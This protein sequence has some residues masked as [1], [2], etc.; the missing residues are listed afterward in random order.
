MRNLRNHSR[1]KFFNVDAG[2][3]DPGRISLCIVCFILGEFCISLSLEYYFRTANTVLRIGLKG[4]LLPILKSIFI[5]VVLSLVVKFRVAR[6]NNL[7][8]ILTLPLALTSSAGH[9]M[10]LGSNVCFRGRGR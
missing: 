8:I 1:H 7:F 4:L 10:Q 3:L 5:H 6:P 9:A 2:D